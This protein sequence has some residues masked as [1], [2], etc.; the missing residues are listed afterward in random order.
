M[1]SVE[2]SQDKL[3]LFR[4][5]RFV[6]GTSVSRLYHIFTTHASLLLLD[7]TSMIFEDGRVGRPDASHDVGS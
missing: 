7:W 4:L 2:L 6:L 5:F 3:S 1:C